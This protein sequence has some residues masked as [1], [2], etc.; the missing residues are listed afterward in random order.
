MYGVAYA[1]RKKA[2]NSFMYIVSDTFAMQNA[3]SM[4]FVWYQHQ[5]QPTNKTIAQDQMFVIQALFQSSVDV[6]V[7]A[8]SS[9][10]F[11]PLKLEF[12]NTKKGGYFVDQM[13]DR[14]VERERTEEKYIRFQFYRI[15]ST[16]FTWHCVTTSIVFLIYSQRMLKSASLS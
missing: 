6:Y 14:E 5:H 8:R 16:D 13:K 11:W 1:F 15:G 9:F 2:L 3:Q 12:Q 4:E 7:C 10:R